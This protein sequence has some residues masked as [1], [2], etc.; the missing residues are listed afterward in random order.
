M[1]LFTGKWPIGF[2]SYI[3]RYPVGSEIPPHT[4][5]VKELRHFRLN[6]VIKRSKVG[7]RFVCQDPIFETERIKLFRPDKSEHSVT[8]VEGSSR[9]LLSIG[10]AI[11]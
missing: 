11:K 10:W 3:I 6:I 7:G 9:Y 1:L 5:P 8:R 4:D 2:D